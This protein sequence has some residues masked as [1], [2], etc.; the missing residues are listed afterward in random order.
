MATRPENARYEAKRQSEGWVRGPRITGAA[1]ARLRDLAYLHK[2]DPCV[3]VSRL[4]LDIPLGDVVPAA[5]IGVAGAEGRARAEF[6]RRNRLSDAEMVDMDRNV[7]S[8]QA[9]QQ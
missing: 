4:L 7:E 9:L 2:L 8:Y 3:V 5:V 1:A 6:Q